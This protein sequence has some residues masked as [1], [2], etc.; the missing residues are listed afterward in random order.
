[1]AV[2]TGH[3]YFNILMYL[4]LG[5]D[6]ELL[7]V[8]ITLAAFNAK[9]LLNDDCFYLIPGKRKKNYEKEGNLH[10]SICKAQEKP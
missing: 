9:P 3:E 10:L 6:A 7:K 8:E 1:M 2:N 4:F 5:D